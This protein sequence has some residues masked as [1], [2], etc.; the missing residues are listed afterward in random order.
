[1]ASALPVL[2]RECHRLRRHLRELHDEIERGPRVL[3]AQQ[4]KLAAE[5]QAHKDAYETIKQLKLKQ[6]ADEGS[7]KTIEAQLEKLGTRAME[8]TTM[9]EMDATK[10]EIAMATAKKN[11]FEDAVLTSILEIEERTNDLPNV[12]KRW[13]D[14][15]AE[16][17]QYQI[18]AKERLEAMLLDQKDCTLKLAEKD[19]QLPE[20]VRSLYDRI[21]K[22]NGPDAL[23][24]VKNRACQQCRTQMTEDK[25]DQLISGHLLC[26]PNCGRMLYPAE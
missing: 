9:K 1:M 8:V 19:A 2:L 12:E 7:L 5:E 25:A 26:C 21:V 10:N 15:Q 17:K 6:K 14:A 4:N 18:D 13:A 22:K 23:A 16:F 20:D 24:G 3:K 11:S